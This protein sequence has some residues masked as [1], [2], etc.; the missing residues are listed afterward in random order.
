MRIRNNEGKINQDKILRRRLLWWI[1]QMDHIMRG[2]DLYRGLCQ[3]R[4][5]EVMIRRKVLQRN[6]NHLILEVV[7]GVEIHDRYLGVHWTTNII[8]EGH[9][10]GVEV[11]VGH[12]H[13]LKRAK[14]GTT[15]ARAHH[16]QSGRNTEKG[17]FLLFF[18]RKT[19]NKLIFLC[20]SDK[21]YD[22]RSR[23]PDRDR[24]INGSD[25][26]DRSRD[27]YDYDY[28]RDRYEKNYSKSSYKDYKERRSR[29]KERNNGKD[30]Y[31]NDHHSSKYRDR[32]RDRRR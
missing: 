30:K 3:S 32:S 8:G 23:T 29:E 24:Y 21:K 6:N 12:G 9:E 17:T 13:L 14:R 25:K 31:R 7:A 5:P 19:L 11:E 18:F 15:H 2:V 27:R 20:Y 1:E 26:R 22:K 16:H 10:I 28:G 4:L